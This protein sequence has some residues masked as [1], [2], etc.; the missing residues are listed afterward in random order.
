[1]FSPTKSINESIGK[2]A[3]GDLTKEEKETKREIRRITKKFENQPRRAEVG[4]CVKIHTKELLEPKCFERMKTPYIYGI[5]SNMED[6]C[7]HTSFKAFQVNKSTEH[8]YLGDS[9]LNFVAVQFEHDMEIVKFEDE[10]DEGED[11][12]FTRQFTKIEGMWQHIVRLTCEYCSMKNYNHCLYGD[13][14]DEKLD[15][16]EMEDGR[17][18]EKRYRMYRAFTFLKHG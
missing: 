13:E 7:E 10:E 8:I 3:P 6:Q 15:A 16:V 18:N 9:F 4:C 12:E 17:I 2:E 1:M 5:I 11:Y 14:L